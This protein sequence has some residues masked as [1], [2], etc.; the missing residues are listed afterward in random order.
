MFGGIGLSSTPMPLA[1][2]L[3]PAQFANI[4]AE[5]MRASIDLAMA[6]CGEGRPGVDLV[7]GF[8]SSF[9][10]MLGR[11]RSTGICPSIHSV[12]GFVVH[13]SA[14]ELR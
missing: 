2:Q 9:E 12:T 11:S 10:G 5:H 13:A 1:L 3:D 8:G 6:L 7:G 4:V 14:D